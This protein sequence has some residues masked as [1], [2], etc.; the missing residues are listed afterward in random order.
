M[1]SLFGMNIDVLAS[2]PPWWLYIP[3]AV[4]TVL[5]TL[6]VWLI[7]KYSNVCLPS[8]FPIY[9]LLMQDIASGQYRRFIQPSYDL[10]GIS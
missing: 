5:L 9:P 4:V 3:F 1:Q 6:V 8:P 7:F 10:A 2:N